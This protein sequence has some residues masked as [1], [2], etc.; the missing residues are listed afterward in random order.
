MCGIVGLIG[1]F[2][3]EEGAAVCTRMNEAIAHRG[4]DDH[5][6]FATDGFAF[7]MRRLSIIDL[8]GGHQPMWGEGP[9]AV[10]IV[11]NGEIYNYLEIRE[12]LAAAGHRF[13][14]RSDTE[15]ILRLYEAEGIEG[16]S[17]L[18]GMFAICIY[19]PRNRVVH[20]IRDRLGIKPLYYGRK[21]GTLFFASEIKAI[22]AAM[23]ERPDLNRQALH[24]Y[25][26][27]RFVP[28]PLSIWQD[29]AKLEPGHRL[30]VDLDSRRETIVRTWNADENP[31]AL[32]PG[33]D[34]LAEFEELFLSAVDKRLIAS[35]VPVGVFLSGGLDSSAIGAAAIELGHKNFH[36]FSIGFREG[37]EFSELRYAR[38]VA[39][40]IGS[41]HHEVQIG[42]QEFVD[43]LP[44]LVYI[45]DEPLADHAGVPLNYVS[46]LA[47][48]YVK[49]V[50]SGEG[51]DEILAGYRMNES[52]AHLDRLQLLYRLTPG[53][54]R[55][56]LAALAPTSARA[57]LEAMVGSD[58]SHYYRNR[59]S[60]FIKAWSEEEKTAFWGHGHN[61]ASTD[62]LI[63]SWYDDA[64][65]HH[66]LAQFLQVLRRQWLVEDLLNKADKI[67]MANALELRV[68]F[69]DH[70]LVEWSAR[71]PIEWK[72]G[73]RRGGYTSKRVLREFC[74]KRLPAEILTRPKQGFPVP[75]TKWLEGDLGPWA[76]DL[77]MNSPRLGSLFDTKAAG[78]TLAAARRGDSRSANKVWILIVLDYWLAAWQ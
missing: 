9:D 74:S 62:E 72:V 58:W 64:P 16:L 1:S 14:T 18:H 59:A 12:K 69:L 36:T 70:L 10:G 21:N 39:E 49:V 54:L 77:I 40:R 71:L 42:A 50:L 51:S 13:S 44:R 48:K 68:P 29:I 47:R 31:E 63:R 5:G 75:K 32:D 23:G 20:L 60:Y 33:R 15:V 56:V 52:A 67:S 2:S 19:D 17:R 6:D 61:L 25:L 45:T 78:P 34:Y 57:A 35:D 65:A 26:T 27:F 38:M 8:S 41:Q 53:P 37:G 73:S 24:H 30:S 7:A 4:P 3:R 66:P 11:F 46:E 22:I 55:S 43:F 76:E 28:S